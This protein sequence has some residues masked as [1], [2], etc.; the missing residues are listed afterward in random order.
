M[1][2][3]ATHPSPKVLTQNCS[4]L[5]EIQEQRVEQKQKKRPCRDCPP[6]DPSHMQTPNLATIADAKKYL[7]TGS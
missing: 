5:K 2:S 6:G 1:A 4:C 3:Q 7:L